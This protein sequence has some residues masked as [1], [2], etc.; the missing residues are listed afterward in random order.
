MDIEEQD[1]NLDAKRMFQQASSAFG[2]PQGTV[3]LAY[4]RKPLGGRAIGQ[5]GKGTPK[6]KVGRAPSK[7]KV[8]RAMKSSKSHPPKKYGQ[9][10]IGWE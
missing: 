5:K 2:L 7:G 3:G 1:P 4:P 10:P 9:S 8:G 6:G